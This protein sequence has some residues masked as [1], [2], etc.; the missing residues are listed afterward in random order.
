MEMPGSWSDADG[1][2]ANCLCETI[3]KANLEIII[4]VPAYSFSPPNFFFFI[5]ILS[6]YFSFLSIYRK[7]LCSSNA[8]YP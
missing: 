5:V 7:Y 8:P 1:E 4:S 2:L 3:I 6:L